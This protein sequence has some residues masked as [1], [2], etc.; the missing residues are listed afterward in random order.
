[1]KYRYHLKNHILFILILISL[2]SFSQSIA[3]Y[4]IVF[5]SLWNETDHGTLPNN[6][7]WSALVGSN[8]NNNI[9]FLKLNGI[10]TQGIEDIAEIGSF[11]EF[12]DQEVIPNVILGNAEQFINGGG[13][14]SATGTISI[15]N[16]MMSEAYPLITLVSMIAP[17]PDWIIT[18]HDLNL[19]SGNNAVNNGWKDTFSLDLFVYDAGTDSGIAYSSDNADETPHTSINSLKGISPFN[20]NKIGTISFTYNSSTLSL[21][22]HNIFEKV[23]LYPNPS[24]G[25][26]IISN[27]SGINL[28]RIEIYNVFGRLVKHIYARNGISKLNI[29]LTHLKSG[30]YL[31]KLKAENGISKTQKLIIK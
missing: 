2:L 24:T 26:V 23:I 13:L 25:K 29:D 27:I 7:H 11:T 1:M 6:P 22:S 3:N 18:V 12:R 5:Q 14:G 20:N 8:H 30:I 17:S 4:N 15:N 16:L 19:R 31:L 21:E 10:A 9:S 28:K